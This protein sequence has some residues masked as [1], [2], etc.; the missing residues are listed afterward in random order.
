MGMAC[1][2]AAIEA[3]CGC[4]ECEWQRV[5]ACGGRMSRWLAARTHNMDPSSAPA[6][7]LARFLAP[8]ET[9]DVPGRRTVR[10]KLRTSSCRAA[11]V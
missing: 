5:L 7:Q 3:D 8:V 4:F 11:A 9:D 2:A 10:R 1:E 6:S